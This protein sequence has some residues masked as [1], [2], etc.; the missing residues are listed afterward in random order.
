MAVVSTA[1]ATVVV[2]VPVR[3]WPFKTAM[4]RPP[5][6]QV[7]TNIANQMINLL[8]GDAYKVN[9]VSTILPFAQAKVGKGDLILDRTSSRAVVNSVVYHFFSLKTYFF[10]VNDTL[11]LIRTRCVIDQIVAIY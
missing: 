10:E 7:A 2:V 8:L 4:A 9:K 5:V 11:D 1:L 6:T 3:G